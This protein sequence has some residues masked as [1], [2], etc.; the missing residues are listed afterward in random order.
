MV[1][2][3]ELFGATGVVSPK[4]DSYSGKSQSLINPL[5]K[6]ENDLN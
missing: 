4:I 1:L 2:P 5:T 6:E 3:G